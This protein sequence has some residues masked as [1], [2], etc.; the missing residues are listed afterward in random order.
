MNHPVKEQPRQWRVAQAPGALPLV[1]H[2]LTLKRDP[3]A[4]LRSLPAHGDMVKIRLG[5]LTGYLLCDPDLVHQILAA[6]AVFDKGGPVY[7]RVRETMGNGIGTSMNDDHRRQRALMQ[8]SFTHQRIGDYSTAMREEIESTLATWS[9][10]QRIDAA[11]V[12]G[13]L[14]ARITMRA[15]LGSHLTETELTTLPAHLEQFFRLTYRR[16]L[17]PHP[18][19]NRL[20]TRTNKQFD[21]HVTAIRSLARRCVDQQR[22]KGGNPDS[23]IATLIDSGTTTDTF[24]TD[25]LV[26]QI[27][28]LF[29]AGI[30]SA[31]SSLK[32]TIYDLARTPS[33]LARLHR[34]LD[35]V[36]HGRPLTYADLPRMHH[37]N[38]CIT[39][40][41]R[42]NPTGWFFSRTVTTPTTLAGT[43][44]A[45]GTSLFFSPYLLQHLPD[46]YPDPE[47]YLPDRWL[48]DRVTR[49]QAKALLPFG[50]GSRKCIGDTY[51]MTEIALIVAAITSG[52]DLQPDPHAPPPQMSID[53]TLNLRTFPVVCR[54]RKG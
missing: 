49:P 47:T 23:L 34:E 7:D 32:W 6:P 22:E 40:S 25:E 14:L 42:L 29:F 31:Q 24:D 44:L 51:G 15:L 41:L 27:V 9:D 16:L 11:Q 36:L 30:E 8:P 18:V 28:T 10:G 38:R 37:L 3:L 45:A 43:Q 26:D 17:M 53:L 46:I 1:G 54:R 13:R 50:H 52:W 2:A 12:L 39:E 35:D 48:P 20:P 4:F 21:A 33:A 19:L 5:P